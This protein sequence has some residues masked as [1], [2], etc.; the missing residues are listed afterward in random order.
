MDAAAVA[1][2]K[3][4]GTGQAVD[5]LVALAVTNDDAARGNEVE[6]DATGVTASG[7]LVVALALRTGSRSW[8]VPVT[9]GRPVMGEEDRSI[10][11]A[12]PVDAMW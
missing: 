7:G 5:V 6:R 9:S 4:A 8:G 1:Q 2:G 10:G 3:G 12:W 11:R